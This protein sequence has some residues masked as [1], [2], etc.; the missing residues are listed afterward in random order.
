MVAMALQQAGLSATVYEAHDE[1]SADEV[2]SFLNLASNGLDVLRTLR[3]MEAVQAAGFPTS[4]M[5]MFSSTGKRLGEVPNGGR[6]PDGTVSVTLKRG[7]L[8][9]L[10]R[11]EALRR[12]IVIHSGKRLVEA[13]T[14]ADRALATF[15]DGTTASG[16]VLVGADGLHSRIRALLDAANPAPRYTGQLSIGGIA[17]RSALEPTP[18]AYR[19]IFGQ[20]AFFGY[21]VR[22]S[23]EAYW[24]AN[25]QAPPEQAKHPSAEWKTRLLELFAG[26]VGPATSLISATPEVAAWPIFDLPTV[27]TWHRGRLVLLGDAAHATSPSSGQ[28]ASLAMEDALVLALCL[29]DQPEPS[30][31]FAAY[32]RLRRPRVERVVRASARVSNTKVA[33]PVGRVVRDALMPLALRFVASQASQ[34]WLHGYHLDW[35]TKVIA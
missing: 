27:K 14:S 18:D 8:H 17:P 26:D 4:R 13:H 29:R 9:R 30:R 1:A 10:L 19:M 24:F 3:A 5:T 34:T 32:E 23:S 15:A 11:E 12:G 28:G 22:E 31:A 7:V 6:L 20:R 33:G 25:L 16:A 2:G 21:A 35:D